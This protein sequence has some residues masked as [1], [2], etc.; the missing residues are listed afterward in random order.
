[1]QYSGGTKK[2][3]IE[4]ILQTALWVHCNIAASIST[5]Q[6]ENQM[7]KHCNGKMWNSLLAVLLSFSSLLATAQ[8]SYNT[9][10]WRFSN[11]KQFGFTPIDVQFIDNNTAIAVGSDGSIARTTDA[12][13]NWV[14]GCFTFLSAAGATVKPAFSD[15]HFVTPTTA[16]AVGSPGAMVKTTDGGITWTLVKT[17]LYANAKNIN[18]CWFID[19]NKG[20]I[21]GQNNNTIDS[22]PKL[23]VT[24]NGGAT[25]DSIAAP[26]VNGVTRVGYINNPNV[27]SRLWPVDA[28]LKEIYR[29]EFTPSGVGY[30][31]GQA[32]PLFPAVSVNASS[33]TCLPGTGTLTTG[34][35]TAA[36][37]W[38]FENGV[39]TDYSISKERIGY[40]G[41]NT[42]TVT[43][44][45]GFAN[46]TPA[47]QTYRA[48]SIINDSLVVLMSFN[49]NT[50]VRV[51]TG[52]ND[53]TPNLNASNALEKGKYTVL[54]FPFPP[55]GGPQ[56][57]P[58]IPN[59]N[60]LLAS[61]PYVIKKAGNGKLYAS[62]NFGR[63]WSSV[64]TGRNWIQV[65]SLPQGQN[66]SNNGT[67]ALDIAP[68]GRF[69]TLGTNG[70][71]ADSIAG[72]PWKSNYNI[73]SPGAGYNKIEFADCNNGMAAG[74]GTI[75]VTNDGG[76]TWFDRTRTDFVSLNINITSLTYAN[77]NPAV[78]YFATSVGTIYKS[79]NMN[80]APPATPTLDPVF[81]NGNEQVNDVAT[82]GNDSVWACGYS[83]FSVPAA[84]RSPK[85]FR[86]FNGGT[87][88]TT[89]SSFPAGTT[90]QTFTDI[91]FPSR[92]VGY[93]AGSRDTIW[94]TT[95]AGV[96]WSKL[97]LPTPGVTPQI[98]YT[99]MYALDNNTVFLT[100][101]GFPRKVVFRT[102]DGGAT[103]T[104][105]TNN[106]LTLGGGNLNG[107]LFHDVNN[108]YVVGPGGVM[109]VTNNGG[110]T[111]R[112]DIAA[113]SNLFS[114]MAFAPVKVPAGTPFANRRIFVTGPSLPNSTSH[115]LEYG[116]FSLVNVSSTETVVSSCANAAQGSITVNAV[117]GLAPYTYSINGGP[118]QQS[119]VFTGLTPGTKT[120]TIRDFGCNVYTKTVTVP[121]RPVPSVSAGTDKTIVQGY[122]VML[123]GSSAATSP[124]S[125]AWTPANSVLY[126]QG[127]FNIWVKPPV[128]TT[129]T[130]TVT[131][132]NGCIGTDDAVVTVIPVCIK[133]MNAF[134][135]NG[136][137][138][139]DRWLVTNGGSCTRQIAVKIFNRYGELV[140]S[141]DNYNNEWDGTYKGK[142]VADGT[143]YYTIQFH[144]INGTIVPAKG[145]V[146]ILR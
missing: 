38:K 56:A 96:T 45:T 121:V 69:L 145:D 119:N 67:W 28:K 21:A 10:N 102:T 138:I 80:V 73:V 63:F 95:D 29:I 105:I 42:N 9:T 24:L 142:P 79:I 141:N 129:Y 83:G 18:A 91:E 78:A 120:I 98:T 23:Y 74:G 113:S 82:V 92:Q 58:P 134:S 101:N 110:A 43:C 97:P 84:S 39:L 106:I 7:N 100:G 107:V 85:I 41:I 19:A 68:N 8:S 72:S 48:M 89:V 123:N 104:D 125:I 131:D 88:W 6:N 57:G 51:S 53:F 25:W 35:H 112:L 34:A 70:V 12:G 4:L 22:L 1:M 52:V 93:V 137:A 36:L 86:S 130:L 13:N 61:N 109:Y 64:D 133:V 94:K 37:L 90:S 47:A 3:R 122:D 108:G 75:T 5:N 31:C 124:T 140:Y 49:N 111:W 117:G 65:N 143:Y 62:G 99:D 30:I 118:A 50:V 2:N 81:A 44:T 26:P 136:D 14:Y 139:N 127:T 144:L 55:T 46:L 87:T 33:T 11:P 20:Y 77:G 54:N 114:T 59:P 115:I 146:T 27:P 126:G 116:N 60:V 135:P 71:V 66:Y 40:S 15:V 128:T 132:A 17:P 32:S 103:W 76:K 16:Y